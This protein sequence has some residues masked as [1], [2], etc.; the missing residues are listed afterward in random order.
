MCSIQLGHCLLQNLYRVSMG[1]IYKF[2]QLQF[3]FL[4][5][6]L[7]KCLLPNLAN[8]SHDGICFVVL[9]QCSCF[10]ITEWSLAPAE[11]LQ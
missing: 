10:L 7:F 11:E 6:V 1:Q 5:T 2:N 8:S 3:E 4:C 9:C